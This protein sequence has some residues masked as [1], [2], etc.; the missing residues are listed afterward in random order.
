M[1][2]SVQTSNALNDAEQQKLAPPIPILLLMR[3]ALV[4]PLRLARDPST[5]SAHGIERSYNKC[6]ADMQGIIFIYYHVVSSVSY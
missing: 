1:R 2:T 5:S 4:E 6:T 3:Y